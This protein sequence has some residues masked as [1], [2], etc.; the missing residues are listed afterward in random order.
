M[1]GL[2]TILLGHAFGGGEEL[3]EK[4]VRPVLV[5]NCQPCHGA[6]NQS[7]GLRL[8][9][10]AAA[11]KGGSKGPALVPGKPEESLLIRAVRHD[12]LKMPVGGKLKDDEIAALEEWVRSGAAWPQSASRNEAN[13]QHWAFLPV[14]AAAGKPVD[15]HLIESMAK[16][17]LQMSAAADRRT[18]IRRLSF[19]LTGLPPTPGEVDRFVKDA[20]P[21]AWSRVVDRLLAS[22]HYGEHWARHWMDVMRFGETHG[23]EWNYEIHNAWRY[24]DYLIRA[25]NMDVPFDHLIREHLAGDLLDRPRVNLREGINESVIGASSFRVGEV[26]HDDCLTFREIRTDAVD[27]QIDTITKAF[28]GLTVACARC[29]DHKLDPIPAEDYYA[30]YGILNS[31]R[32]V[33]RTVDLPGRDAGITERLREMKRGIREEMARVWLGE[34]DGIA[35]K[36]RALEPRDVPPDHPLSVWFRSKKTPLAELA[37]SYEREARERAAFNASNFTPFADFG[38]GFAAGWQSDGLGLRDGLARSG[39]F[40]VAAEGAQ[41]LAAIYPAGLY[42]NLISEKWNGALRSPY[43]PKDRKYIS[44]QVVGGK[45][46]AR[47]TITDNC[48]I[49]ED[50][51]LLD[52]PAPKWMKWNTAADRKQLPVYLELVTKSDNPRLPDR[53]DRMKKLTGS[54]DSPRSYFGVTRA[55]LHDTNEAPRAPLS[56]MLRLFESS[57]DVG[58]RYAA[59]ARQAVTAWAENRA[60]D[61]EVRWLQ[62]LMESKLLS[63][64]VPASGRLWELIAAYRKLEARLAEPSVVNTMADFDAGVDFPLLKGGDAKRMGD[65]VPRHY[66]K[67]LG[68]AAPIATHGSG[69]RELAEMIASPENPLTARVFVNRV[70]GQLF[71]GG[72]VATTD[73]FGR[74]GETPSHP[75]LLDSIAAR[76]VEQGWSTK[77][78]IRE[79]VL[80]QAFQQTS[81]ASKEAAEADP[82]NRLLSH[83]PVRRLEAESIRDLILATSGRLDA[84][85]YGVSI[86]PHRDEVK[87]YRKLL[88]GPLDGDGRRSIYIKVTRMEGPRFLELFDFPA[89]SVARGNRDIT[90]V[91]AQA[92]ALLNDPFVIGQARFWAERL[93]KD[94]AATAEDRIDRMFQRALG[95]QASAAERER[96]RGLAY[97]AGSLYNVPR[98]GMMESAAIWKDVAHT[99]FNLK[100]FIY[101]Q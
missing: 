97:Q 86:H 84:K 55:V 88:A 22:P 46:A 31:S 73:N 7:S 47:R 54:M 25:F 26:G 10:R 72:L 41:V 32:Q 61:D 44:L 63:N 11:L 29:H 17:G 8:D 14:K 13:S 12:G 100:E 27:N 15:P 42:T 98:E 87:D 30:L 60:N 16:A 79:L 35:A 19:V 34:V 2:L 37:A 4:R 70:W 50:Y 101:L 68:K 58:E 24:R 82:L 28:Q 20:A 75:E 59:V 71:G 65:P 89:P 93:V 85:L 78:L 39:D 53:P 66:L 57:G 1:L 36:L 94:G 49:G 81:V 76:F 40:A 52:Q 69:R 99:L 23:Y 83:Y 6:A 21:D 56:H 67:V 3:F 33:T 45:L 92:L 51:E 80:T 90:N 95:R 9:S 38:G 5:R 18:L 64:E 48:A 77:R 62:S 91:P 96:F 43:L 74:F